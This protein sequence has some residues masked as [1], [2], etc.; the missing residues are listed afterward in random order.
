M[1]DLPAPAPPV[2]PGS[3]WKLVPPGMAALIRDKVSRLEAESRTV[4]PDMVRAAQI[5]AEIAAALAFAWD[6]AE[7]GARSRCREAQWAADSDRA[8]AAAEVP[9]TDAEREARMERAEAFYEIARAEEVTAASSR[10]AARLRAETLSDRALRATFG[11][12]DSAP[13][14][15]HLAVEEKPRESDEPDLD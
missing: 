15:N 9:E 10:R 7:V 3:P 2:D 12:P 8:A 5:D 14:I 13:D 4:G 1:P 11:P 6:L